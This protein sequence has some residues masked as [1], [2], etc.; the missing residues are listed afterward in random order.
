MDPLF[1]VFP[2]PGTSF[3]SLASFSILPV[4]SEKPHRP[5]TPWEKGDTHFSGRVVASFR[6][7]NEVLRNKL[8]FGLVTGAKSGG[9]FGVLVADSPTIP[10]V[11]EERTDGGMGSSSSSPPTGSSSS[12]PIGSSSSSSPP[13]LERQLHQ[14]LAEYVAEQMTFQFDISDP[15]QPRGGG[16][17]GGGGGSSQRQLR[18]VQLN[19]V[20]Q[21]LF[22][23][24]TL[25]SITLPQ[26]LGW[27]VARDKEIW[28][29][30]LHSRHEEGEHATGSRYRDRAIDR[31]TRVRVV[32]L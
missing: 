14:L 25:V 16:G 21:M 31:H 5:S 18:S 4:F 17:G 1:C 30:H 13:T 29:Q 8:V 10:V 26:L 11:E 20:P 32:V 6:I 22:M 27:F 28:N 9:A 2:F 19:H 7:R 12:P 23:K 3:F 24:T 15:E